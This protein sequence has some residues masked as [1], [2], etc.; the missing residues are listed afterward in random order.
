[1]I[2]SFVLIRRQLVKMHK[3]GSAMDAM[4]TYA[5]TQSAC[6][7]KNRGQC[8]IHEALHECR[9]F[10][11]HNFIVTCINFLSDGIYVAI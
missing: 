5:N 1:M 7:R 6:M 11:L 2:L 8:M 4:P 9:V 10:P 3:Y